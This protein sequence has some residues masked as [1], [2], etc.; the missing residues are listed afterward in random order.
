[1]G[2]VGIYSWR[3]EAS[4]GG[5]NMGA[6]DSAKAEWRVAGV[7]KAIKVLMLVHMSAKRTNVATR[8]APANEF[9]RKNQK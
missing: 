3:S 4:K 7:L 8:E 5:V 6:V 2:N 9:S 1:M